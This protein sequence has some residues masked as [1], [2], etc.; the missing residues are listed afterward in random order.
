MEIEKD[1]KI[2]ESPFKKEFEKVVVLLEELNKKKE[3]YQV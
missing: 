2:E 3:S 1:N